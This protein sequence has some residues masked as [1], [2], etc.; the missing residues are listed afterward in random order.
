MMILGVT[1]QAQEFDFSCSDD[2]TVTINYIIGGGYENIV[3]V[4]TVEEGSKSWN[5]DIDL[6]E[7]VTAKNSLFNY[8]YGETFSEIFVSTNKNSDGTGVLALL[9]VSLS[10]GYDYTVSDVVNVDLSDDLNYPADSVT[11]TVNYTIGGGF[12]VQSLEIQAGDDVDYYDTGIDLPSGVTL[13]EVLDGLDLGATW[14]NITQGS[15]GSSEITGTLTLGESFN[16]DLE[17]QTIAIDLSDKLNYP[18]V[19]SVTIKMKFAEGLTKDYTFVEGQSKTI[20]LS[21]TLPEGFSIIKDI[22]AENKIE[23]SITYKRSARNI[24]DPTLGYTITV[25]SNFD[26]TQA[27]WE[28]DATGEFASYLSVPGPPDEVTVKVKFAEGFTH[29]VVFTEGGGIVSASVPLPEGWSLKSQ[30]LEYPNGG[31]FANHGT[32]IPSIAWSRSYRHSSK[33]DVG[34]RMRPSTEILASAPAFDYTQADFTFDVSLHYKN[35]FNIPAPN[36][37]TDITVKGYGDLT[38]V[39]TISSDDGK[40]KYTY[41]IPLPA[42]YFYQSASTGYVNSVNYS[43]ITYKILSQPKGSQSTTIE[44]TPKSNFNY[45]GNA[46]TIDFGDLNSDNIGIGPGQLS[47]PGNMFDIISNSEGTPSVVPETTTTKVR[48]KLKVTSANANWYTH[49]PSNDN[50]VFAYGGSRIHRWTGN[51]LNQEAASSSN[52]NQWKKELVVG[53]TFNDYT[54][55]SEADSTYDVFI[56]WYDGTSKYDLIIITH[57]DFNYNT[58]QKTAGGSYFDM[59]AHTYGTMRYFDVALDLNGTPKNVGTRT[60]D[61]W[62]QVDDN[63]FTVEKTNQINGVNQVGTIGD[64]NIIKFGGAL[65]QQWLDSNRDT[66]YSSDDA[67]FDD[68]RVYGGEYHGYVMVANPWP[69]NG[70]NVKVFAQ[71]D[72]NSNIAK[73]IGVFEKGINWTHGDYKIN[74][75]KFVPGKLWNYGCNCFND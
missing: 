42:G 47:Y 51:T 69:D 2:T 41:T 29:D 10:K 63:S 65:N 13:I 52:W 14:A 45:T 56:R 64:S 8:F 15:A 19:D 71:W 16:Y 46:W 21:T 22:I 44:I 24:G 55:I 31:G 26:Y 75:I 27:D 38:D 36:N 48:V 11:V 72:I 49:I 34:I 30:I 23:N 6:P 9:G 39:N 33:T 17:G 66:A 1:S 73:I 4:I 54:R 58:S 59:R 43:T 32:N 57:D 37:P 60:F 61:Y 70:G 25:P 3:K 67:A 53:G 40:S 50:L 35:H 12:P 7:G 74:N 20:G 62:F 5:A 68:R 18:A 28:E